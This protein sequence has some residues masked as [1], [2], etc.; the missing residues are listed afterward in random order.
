MANMVVL[1]D[2]E[3]PA[4]L[5]QQRRAP[6]ANFTPCADADSA[7]CGER[8]ASTRWLLLN[9]VWKFAYAASPAEAPAAFEQPAFDDAAWAD[10]PVPSC[11]QCHGYGRPHYTNVVY[12]FPVDPPR[13][14][15]ENPTGAYRRV[16][17]VPEHWR[18]MRVLL[19]FEGVDAAFHVWVNGHAIGFSKGSRM[20][21][22]FDITTALRDGENVLAVRVY[23]WCDGSY[24]ED[25]DMWW[26]SGIFRDVALLAVPPTHIADL[27]VQTP[28]D[29]HA[30]TA[31]LQV[32]V[33]LETTRARGEACTVRAR[34]RDADGTAVLPRPLRAA[35][36]VAARG[37]AVCALS[38]SVPAPHLW[39]AEDPYLYRLL[40]ELLDEAGA[41]REAVALKIGF[42]S[43]SV[44]N[45]TLCVNGVPV[46]LKG[47]NRHEHHPQLGRAVPFEAMRQ[48]IL[49]MKRH[50]INAVRT[51]HYP[52]DPRFY[53]L[54][55]EYGIYV[56]DEADLETHGFQVS[57]DWSQLSKDPAWQAA[58][59]ERAVRMVAR[60]K[61]HPC[62]IMWSLGNEAGYGPNHAAMAQ[63]IRA[64]D[65]TRLVHYERDLDAHVSD[66]V[67][68][69]YTHVDKVIEYGAQP[70]ATKPFF[71]CEYAHAMGNGPGGLKEY[72][73]AIYAAPRLAGGCVWE[74]LDHGLC[75]TT[76]D[77]RPYYAYGG[78]FG[79]TPHDGNF[80][81]DGLL[82]PDR[83]PSP[84]LIE[85]KKVLEPVLVE[86]VDLA[87]GTVRVTNRYDFLSLAHLQPV[88]HISA[89]G[90]VLQ[91]GALPPLHLAAQRS[92]TVQVPST[93]PPAQ[94]ATEYWLT[95]Q[96]LQ[97]TPTCWCEAGHEVA[98]A[99]FR[100]PCKV[101][102]APLP[103]V[104][105]PLRLERHATT[106]RIAGPDFSITFDTIRGRIT[107][108]C[109]QG[110]ALMHAG[111]RVNIWRALTDN[112]V[113]FG[114]PLG[115]AWRKCHLDKLQHRVAA[116]DIE[117]LDPA[118]IRVTVHTTAAPPVF[119]L[120]LDCVYTYFVYGSG[121]VLLTVAVT[122]RGAW[123]AAIPRMGVQLRLPRTLE[124]VTWYGRGP[125]EAY[126]D[127][128][129]AQRIG[130]YEKCL[131]EL[132]TRYI[133][134]QE[135]GNR[136][137]VR[138]ATFTDTRGVGLLAAGCP[139]INVSAHRFTPEDF[140]RA[141]HLHE[142]T[143]RD[144][145][146]LHLDHRQHGIGSGSCGPTTL[147]Q[148]CLQ[149]EPMTYSV[150]LAPHARTAGTAAEHAKRL[151]RGRGQA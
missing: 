36:R 127:T 147:P 62:V 125:G 82:F 100:L 103:L 68:Q 146:I 50:N 10:L 142:L 59:V 47:V 18:G 42:R 139:T 40:I 76:P 13:V 81:I 116:C 97:A 129:L 56:V 132:W 117:Q 106:A 65:P 6:R 53:D 98:W 29:P 2:L 91:S 119:N 39:S 137:D 35:A 31:E 93:L 28:L 105:A 16:F 141:R 135:N 23:Q 70:G 79:D 26:L 109:A 51:S 33:T 114:S 149:T 130:V 123:P 24:L 64:L 44:R 144:E 85:Y 138:W 92:K 90:V 96:F 99:Q 128:C 34:L 52:D 19:R 101:K 4:V 43:V 143:P 48:D 3:N 124:H 61:N 71:L 108:W 37:I 46:K 57:G 104:A 78:D 80:V 121:D 9:G 1:S 45:A 126:V 63:A 72:W 30:A 22:E 11:W 58:F 66:V 77:G 84:G 15:S 20:P 89:D 55:D 134:P 41:V 75:A 110:V 25:Q 107:A 49:L 122:P 145:I 148:Y 140:D 32:Q 8:A 113:G 83:T 136:A 21:A 73:D 151:A 88:W 74:W 5:A 111:P 133:V 17:C 120:A 94:P 95:L 14:P 131:D 102:T 115:A 60:D 67:S 112:D 54:C 38:A 86:P 69:M 27:A 118:C 7:L 150:W 12:P 87:R